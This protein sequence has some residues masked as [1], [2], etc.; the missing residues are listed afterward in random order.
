MR[1][2]RERGNREKNRTG[3]STGTNSQNRPEPC[4]KVDSK[5]RTWKKFENWEVS[6]Q[7]VNFKLTLN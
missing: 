2:T 7:V 1:R 6:K 5:K 4:P 3:K